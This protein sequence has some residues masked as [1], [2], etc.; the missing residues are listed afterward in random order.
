MTFRIVLDATYQRQPFGGIT[1]YARQLTS[2][3]RDRGDVDITEIGG[4]PPVPRGSVRQRLLT[5]GTDLLWHPFVGRLRASAV[6]ADVYH[7]L[8]F[9]GPLT[10][11][12]VPIVVTVFDVVPILY[13]EL[14]PRWRR[15]Y[16]VATQKRKARVA[17]LVLCISGNTAD[18]VVRLLGVAPERVRVTPLGVEPVFFAS[19]TGA[20]PIVE[21]YVLFIGSEQPRKNLERLEKAVAILRARGHPHILVTAGADSW[22]RVEF[23]DTFVRKLGKVSDE[24]L[25]G[26][27]AG[28]A[29]LAIPSLHEGFGLPALEAMAAGAPVVA[30]NTAALP[31]VTGG[32]AVLVDPLDVEDI[33]E[34]LERAFAER[35]TLVVAGRRRAAEF[36]WANTAELTMK[37]YRELV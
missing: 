10:R 20:A 23:G 5:I 24:E 3:L 25:R 14:S 27:Y 8:G 18:D 17:D 29:C 12:R 22:G 15:H 33:A 28:A 31:E 32:A 36:T 13:R 37:A 6:G 30:A 19:V 21:P 11:G 9:K 16:D 1:R 34:G 35:D 2:A 26:L 7:S 4:G